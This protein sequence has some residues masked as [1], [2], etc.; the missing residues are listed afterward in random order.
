M[1]AITL[2]DLAKRK[3]ADDEVGLIDET[4]RATPEVSGMN[5]L[6]GQQVDKMG[7][8]KTIRSTIY[9]TRVRTGLPTVGFRDIN[10][11]TATTKQTT[12]NRAVSCHLLNPRW[13]ADLGI[14]GF[15]SDLMEELAE[16]AE[17]H[18][19]AAFQQLGKSHYYGTNTSF[20]GHAKSFPGLIDAVDS[21]MVVDAGGTTDE[22][23]T[24]VWGL[25]YG[26]QAVR[27]VLGNDG[28]FDIK[29]PREKDATDDDGNEYTVLL[30]ELYAHVGLQVSS[31]HC[32]GRIKK[33]TEDSGKGLTT[34]LLRSL[35][36]KFADVGKRP[37]V[38]VMTQR[39]YDQYEAHLESLSVSPSEATRFG[40]RGVPFVITNSISDVETLAL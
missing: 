33:L 22:T 20:G 3:V 13:E 7:D 24:S 31:T 38:F 16:N 12:E 9:K 11:G 25:C 18:L 23:A 4:M 19:E 30:Q 26:R 14:D 34:T 32:V 2:L 17:A 39:S 15:D 29:D 37:D 8:A 28:Q 27:W 36:R 40:F 6:T 5:L 21:S 35:Y 10:T 1:A